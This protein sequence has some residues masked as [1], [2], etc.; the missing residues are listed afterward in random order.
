MGNQGSSLI[1]C[2]TWHS[3]EDFLPGRV[4]WWESMWR[5]PDRLDLKRILGP[6]RILLIGTGGDKTG[7]F[8]A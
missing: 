6:I 2:D 4:S 1:M 8:V 3:P 5:Q 7:F